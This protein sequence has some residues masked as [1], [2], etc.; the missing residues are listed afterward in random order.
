MAEYT[1]FIELRIDDSLFGMRLDSAALK[2]LERRCEQDEDLAAW[3]DEQA[4]SRSKLSRWIQ[5]EF[6][7]CSGKALKPGM[8]IKDPLVLKLFPPQEAGPELEAD[9]SVEIDIVYEDAALI[10][11]NKQPG[12]VVHPGAGNSSGTLVNGL[13][14]YLGE[15]LERS[16]GESRPGL[17]HRLDKDTSGLM[18][19]AKTARSYKRLVDQFSDR[20]ISRTYF[21]LVGREPKGSYTIENPIGRDPKNRIRMA[22]DVPGARNA[23]TH[24]AV[25][26]ALTHG[27]LLRVS[28]ETGRTHQIRVHLRHRGA[29]IVGDPVYGLVDS[30]VPNLR[31][32]ANAFGRQALHAACLS[33]IH[34]DSEKKV[35]FVVEMPDD[36]LDLIN[37]FDR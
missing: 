27:F 2:A 12:L 5:N 16:G 4:V 11:L 6:I 23:V 21:A 22:C 33:F 30:V 25:E 9:S 14:A 1:D 37:D 15:E 10:V 3:F 29:A 13:I 19:V 28:L 20:S 26:R 36:M 8:K 35:E 31:G 32:R 18:V 17:V 7:A 24:W 34:P